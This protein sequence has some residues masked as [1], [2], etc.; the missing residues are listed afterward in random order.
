M[1]KYAVVIGVGSGGDATLMA[2][3][4]LKK[5]DFTT[6]KLLKDRKATLPVVVQAVD[7]LVQ[8]TTEDDEA[9]FFFSGHGLT[10]KLALKDSF[11]TAAQ[12]RSL[13]LPLKSHKVFIAIQ[14]C[15][16]GSFINDL[17]GVNR[18]VVSSAQPDTW[19]VDN[20]RYSLWGYKFL[21][22]GIV[23]GLADTNEDGLV[24]MQ[25]AYAYSSLGMMSDQ[26]G[27]PFYL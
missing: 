14:A 23:K 18:V 26:Y 11:L 3:R 16:S 17:E 22:Q 9:V 20:T 2:R 27:Q 8:T 13:L 1:N 25:E 12:L 21:L 10:D 7:W 6:V 5:A 4:I 24:S 19:S 15:Y